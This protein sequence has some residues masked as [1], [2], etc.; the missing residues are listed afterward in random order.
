MGSF[1]RISGGVDLHAASCI[2][3]VIEFSASSISSGCFNL[4]LRFMLSLVWVCKAFQS[5]VGDISLGGLGL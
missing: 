2:R 3:H 4:I 5:V 1:P